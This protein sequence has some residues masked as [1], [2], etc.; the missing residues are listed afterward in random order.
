MLFRSMKVTMEKIKLF[1]AYRIKQLLN[2]YDNHVKE[3]GSGGA[4]S[5]VDEMEM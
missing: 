3:E 5:E 2:E 1:P 4:I